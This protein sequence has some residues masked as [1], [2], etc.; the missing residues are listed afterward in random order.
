MFIILYMMLY[1]Q[2]I[3]LSLLVMEKFE[4][5]RRLENGLKNSLNSN[6]SVTN[7]DIESIV[8]FLLKNKLCSF[9]RIMSISLVV[10]EILEF[11]DFFNP[12]STVILNLNFSITNK[13]SELCFLW[14]T[15]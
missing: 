6:I 1:A 3:L 4:F 2:H 14:Q 10:T 7:E 11:K 9:K 13:D 5:K 12:F 15:N 8:F